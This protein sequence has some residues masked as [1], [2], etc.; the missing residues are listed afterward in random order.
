MAHFRGT[1]QGNRGDASRLGSKDSGLQVTCAGW[2]LGATCHID[3]NKS[4]QRDEISVWI[5]T[6]SGSSYKTDQRFLGTFY[7][8]GNKFVKVGS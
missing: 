5:D 2:R 1:L 4:K 7:R 3:Y 6:G 8:K